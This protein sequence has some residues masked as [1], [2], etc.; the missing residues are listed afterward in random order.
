MFRLSRRVFL[1][2]E[3]PAP[4]RKLGKPHSSKHKHT[5]ARAHTNARERDKKT[6]KQKPKRTNLKMIHFA[7][8]FSKQGKIRLSKYYEPYSQQ[9]RLKLQR[10]V[11]NLILPRPSRLCNVV[12]YKTYKLVYKRYASLYFVFAVDADDNA[13]ITL[14]KIQHF[15]EIL[16]AYFGN[17]CELDLIYQFTKAYYVLDEVFVAGEMQE[18]SKRLVARLVSEQDALVEQ[19]KV[20]DE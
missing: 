18:S 15:V 7:L 6:E 5:P 10:D 14:E 12:D 2:K 4:E 16:D 13:L 3:V 11:M 1:W 9:S 19:M 20:Q 8:L 17:V